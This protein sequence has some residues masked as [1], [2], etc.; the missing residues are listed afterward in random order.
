VAIPK[1][2]TREQGIGLVREFAQDL[3]DRYGVAV[4]FNVHRDDLRKW[5]GSEKGWQDYHAHVLTSTR[6]LGRSGFGEK[7]E[8]ELSDTKRKGLGLGDGA[9]EVARVREL[10][11]VSANRHLEQANQAQRIDRRSL[12][13]QGIDREPTVHLGPHAT[14]LE[15]RGIRSDLGDINRRIEVAYLRGL[16]E[17]RLLAALDRSVIDTRTDLASAMRERD[18][19]RRASPGITEGWAAD[20]LPTSEPDESATSQRGRCRIPWPSCARPPRHRARR[21]SCCPGESLAKSPSAIASRKSRH[22]LRNRA[23]PRKTPTGD[24]SPT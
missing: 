7:A 9:S 5:D 23:R 18:Q 2:L 1:E 11:E 22:G 10:W 8:P 3:A 4:D 17:R 24:G 21:A 16:E 12:K 15:R 19:A 20:A 6:K 13:D 14:D